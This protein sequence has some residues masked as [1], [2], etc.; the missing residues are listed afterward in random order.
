VTSAIHFYSRR[1]GYYEFSNFAPFGFEDNGAYWPTVEHYFQAQKFSAPEHANYREMIRQAKTSKIAK[2]H[3]RTRKIKIRPD[4]EE[5]KDDVMLY[6]L[7]RKFEQHPGLREL[8][9]STGELIL[10][11]ASPYDSYWGSGRQGNGRNRL[12]QLLM[13]VRTEIRLL[14]EKMERDRQFK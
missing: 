8:L 13:Q 14:Q 11:E 6:A 3:G 10:V 2:S 9:L 7:R 5:V 4:W 1:A 12:G